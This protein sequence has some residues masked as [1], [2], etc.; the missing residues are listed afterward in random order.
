MRRAIPFFLLL[1]LAA[2]GAQAQARTYRLDPVHCQVL[3]FVSHLG[4]SRQVGRFT[5]VSG[6]FV[7]DPADWSSASVEASI[8]V[9]SLWLGDEP[10]QRK[11]LSDDFLDA[12]RHPTIQFRSERIE[13]TDADSASVHG[14]LSLRGVSRPVVLALQRNRIGRNSFNLKQTAGFSARTTI[15]RSE[16]GMRRMLAAV[17]DEIEILLEIEGIEE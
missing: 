14:T 16:F 3:F 10:W 7:V 1:M 6:R 13:A 8:A 12:A 4:F 11:V 9:D 15:K 17:G 2:P 5:G